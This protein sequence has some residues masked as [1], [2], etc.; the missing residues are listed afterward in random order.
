MLTN[1]NQRVFEASYFAKCPGDTLTGHTS[2]TANT[3]TCWFLSLRLVQHSF[4]CS[5]FTCSVSK[6]AV[7][8]T[9]LGLQSSSD[10]IAFVH[11]E[12]KCSLAERS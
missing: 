3:T 6:R 11:M 8:N 2:C 9:I 12:Q 4:N 7:L 1:T 5:S 10:R